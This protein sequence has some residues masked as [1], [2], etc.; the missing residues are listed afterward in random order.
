MADF[1]EYPA[2]MA[3][4]DALIVRQEATADHAVVPYSGATLAAGTL[5]PAN[6]FRS[7]LG[8]NGL[9]RKNVLTG[10]AEETYISEHTFRSKHRAV[11]GRGGPDRGYMTNAQIKAE[12][13]RLRGMR[14]SKGDA[15]VAE[16]DNAYVG[17]WAKK[18]KL[19]EY[20]EVDNEDELGSDEEYE[21]MEEDEDDVIQSGTVV[22]AP[23]GSLEKRKEA[24]DLGA[25]TTTF[26]GENQYDYQG[27]TYMHVPQ[28]LD[29]DLKKE[30][31]S[32]T[33]FIP[34]K[35]MFTWK[36]HTGGVTAVRLFPR[37][38]HL[39]LSSGNDGL[40]KIFDM[41]HSRELLRT[42]SGHTKA[43]CDVDFNYDGM[44]FLTASF[45]K[46]MKL[47]DTET[48]TCV[49][50]FSCGKTPFVIKFSPSPEHNNEFLVGTN[51]KILQYDS[52]TGNEIVQEYDHHLGPINTLTFV[53]D[54]NRFMSTSDDRSLRAW[55]YGIPVPIKYIADPEQFALTSAARHPSGKYVLY[56][57][58][59]EIQ[60]YS[61]TDKFRQNRKKSY[62]GHNS[63]GL[64]IDV[65]VSPDGQFV[66]SGDTAG[67]VV[68]WDWK[69]SIRPRQNM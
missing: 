35:H 4:K 29:I 31:G 13:A 28:D 25:E 41:Y 53:D 16:G 18:K 59:N 42:Y 34:K 54:G 23:V 57:A 67:Y 24:E 47:W 44:K 5:G 27:R 52:R 21:I 65:A 10:H 36:H 15:T 46:Q 60:V 55:D 14:E 6:P 38:S 8:Q 66:A 2:N 39:G 68:F 12:N 20:E 37:S 17:P 51:K 9:K 26:H 33:N 19:V 56:Q 30:A 58:S 69:V 63:A 62:R 32:T 22:K 45:D 48:G 3:P 11:E 61:S 64:K 7:G 1:N 43:I 40:V 50:R 49:N